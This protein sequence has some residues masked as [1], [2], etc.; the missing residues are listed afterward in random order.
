[1]G[2]YHTAEVCIKGHHTTSSIEMNPE[3]RSKYCPQCGAA[4]ITKCPGCSTNIRGSHYSPH[5]L[6]IRSY[7]LPNYC[8]Y[9][10]EP[11]PW[12]QQRMSAAQELVDEIE[13]LSEEDRIILKQSIL[14][15]AQDS[16]KTEVASVR[17][18]KLLK[19]SGESIGQALN[20]MVTSLATEAAKKLLGL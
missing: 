17:Y 10:G 8:H 13:D 15:L 4:T 2:E 1:M 14:E 11:L 18:K 16:P 3:F 5:V 7:H 12:T 9:C 20:S 19:K 6:T